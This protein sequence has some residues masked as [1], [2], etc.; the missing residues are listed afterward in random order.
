MN[1][2]DYLALSWCLFTSQLKAD[3]NRYYLGTLWWFL[4]PILYVVVFYFIFSN[5][6]NRDEEFLFGLI[7]GLST[8]KW[9]SSV[10]N[11][12]SFSIVQ[13]KGLVKNFNVNPVVFP[14]NSLLLNTFKYIVI[15]VAVVVLLYTKGA[16]DIAEAP[17]LFLWFATTLSVIFAYQLL[18]CTLMPYLPDL[19][20]IIGNVMLLLMFTSGVIVPLSAMPEA[21]QQIL[22]WNPFVYLIDGIRSVALRGEE[23][24]HQFF[25]L[26]MLG[27]LLISVIG[28]GALYRIKGDIPKR[29]I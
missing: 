28:Y 21:A 13:S 2:I 22:V 6:R 29:L 19:R 8:W 26:L 15:M 20:M 4:E 17:S 9:I 11:Q 27:H 24:D 18:L 16:L 1:K 5:F 25:L 7:C 23:I 12:G 3:V 10:I 14:V